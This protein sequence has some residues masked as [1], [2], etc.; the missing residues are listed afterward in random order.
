VVWQWYGGC[1]VVFLYD[2]SC[3]EGGGVRHE[4]EPP[5]EVRGDQGGTTALGEL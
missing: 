5:A 1:N 4:N 3:G 2:K